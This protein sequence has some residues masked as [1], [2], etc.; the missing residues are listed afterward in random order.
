VL[1]RN[2]TLITISIKLVKPEMALTYEKPVNLF[3]L[4]DKMTFHLFV[5]FSAILTSRN[6]HH[7]MTFA[8]LM[9]RD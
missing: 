5:F 9:S 8:A 7:V 2:R 3:T 1:T 4:S 6:T